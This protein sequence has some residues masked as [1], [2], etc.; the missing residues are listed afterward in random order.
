MALFSDGGIFATKPYICGSN[1]YKKMGA[2]K[3]GEWA[4]AVDGLYWSFIEKQ[5]NFFSKN[6]RLA[7]MLRTLDKM[8]PKRKKRIYKVAQE[9]KERLT[10][11]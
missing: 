1:Y 10:Q 4:E 5:R 8:D 7:V 3:D 11:L 9:Y 2:Y 6:P